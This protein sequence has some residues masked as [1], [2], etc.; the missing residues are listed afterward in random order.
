MRKRLQ[1]MV[2]GLILGAALVATLAPASGRS[3]WGQAP[4]NAKVGTHLFREGVCRDARHLTPVLVHDLTSAQYQCKP[5]FK[6]AP[7]AP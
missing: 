7:G 1:G 5:R 2:L 4:M 6:G 3:E